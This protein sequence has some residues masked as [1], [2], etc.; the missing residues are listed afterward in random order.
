MENNTQQISE[1]IESIQK[2]R[3]R[4][5]KRAPHMFLVAAEAPPGTVGVPERPRSHNKRQIDCLDPQRLIDAVNKPAIHCLVVAC[6][7]EA[8]ATL[9]DEEKDN[10]TS[11]GMGVQLEALHCEAVHLLV[12]S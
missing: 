1:K 10:R 2:W 11:G 12:A 4:S 8:A 9:Q 7:A 5:V 3:W 6:A